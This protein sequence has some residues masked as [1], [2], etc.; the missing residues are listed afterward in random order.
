M[1]LTGPLIGPAE[2][3]AVADDTRLKQEIF[4][5]L[6]K[7][8][9]FAPRNMA[10]VVQRLEHRIVVPKVVGSNPIVR[11]LKKPVPL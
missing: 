3:H 8:Y 5:K 6:G 11:P 10:D 1:I 9:I 2:S 4:L 7:V